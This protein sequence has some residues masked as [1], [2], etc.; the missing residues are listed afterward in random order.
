MRVGFGFLEKDRSNSRPDERIARHGHQHAPLDAGSVRAPR[1]LS[2]GSSSMKKM[3][4]TSG[5]MERL[6]EDI[7]DWAGRRPLLI[8]AKNRNG[9]DACGPCVA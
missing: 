4:G 5:A 8:D 2:D 7:L 3:I 9:T 6:R 1:R